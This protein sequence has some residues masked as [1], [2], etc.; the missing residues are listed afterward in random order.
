M[1]YK[2]EDININNKEDNF[3]DLY[4]SNSID[5]EHISQV[6]KDYIERY[7]IEKFFEGIIS[8]IEIIN[9]NKNSKMILF[10]KFPLMKYITYQTKYEFRENVNRDSE[11]SKK[12]D[13]IKYIEYFIEEINYNKKNTE[14]KAE[15]FYLRATKQLKKLLILE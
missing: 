14:P 7:F 5:N 2:E 15:N 12:Y 6:E 8:T 4:C 1:Y 11:F 10:T 3:E 13:L 9:Q